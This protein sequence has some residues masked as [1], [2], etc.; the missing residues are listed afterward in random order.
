MFGCRA[1]VVAEA[2]RRRDPSADPCGRHRPRFEAPKAF[3]LTSSQIE[4]ICL[5]ESRATGSGVEPVA[6]PGD[7][8]KIPGLA[9]GC[10]STLKGTEAVPSTKTKTKAP[11]TT[12]KTL[13]LCE[14]SLWVS[15]DSALL[16]PLR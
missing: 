2:G 11:Q 6:G 13:R 8:L 1:Q 5:C 16:A 12:H 10:V 7:V 9:D 3:T 15:F 4:C 14:A